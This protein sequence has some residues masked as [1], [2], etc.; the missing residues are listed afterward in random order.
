MIYTQLMLPQHRYFASQKYTRENLLTFFSDSTVGATQLQRLQ[1]QPLS[2]LLLCSAGRWML[3]MERQLDTM[4]RWQQ[5]PMLTIGR[6][7]VTDAKPG[8]AFDA[9]S[10]LKQKQK[11]AD[12][13]DVASNERC[14]VSSA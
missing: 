5:R 2:P 4:D 9:R 14:I 1:Q 3:R 10:V 11:Q 8:A 6:W 12:A 13:C 7:L